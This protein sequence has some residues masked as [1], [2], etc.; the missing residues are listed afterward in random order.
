MD[1][2]TT[3]SFEEFYATHRAL[4]RRVISKL[5]GGATFYRE[6]LIQE[7]WINIWLAYPKLDHAQNVR[8]WVGTIAWRTLCEFLRLKSW[9]HTQAEALDPELAEAIPDFSSGSDIGWEE[10]IY[11]GDAE[12]VLAAFRQL[13]KA[14]QRIVRFL[15]NEYTPTET[16]QTMAGK[17]GEVTRSER[18]VVEKARARFR[19]LYQKEAA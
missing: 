3:P 15:L 17:L 10:L 8:G 12:I 7:S 11:N 5:M 6:E 2:T 14:D 13:D 4:V 18:R 1:E 19:E 16:C 9:R